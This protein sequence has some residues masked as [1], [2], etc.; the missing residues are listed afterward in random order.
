MADLFEYMKWRGDLSFKE[1]R[2]NEIDGMILSRAAYIPYALYLDN[3]QTDVRKVSDI[4]ELLLTTENYKDKVLWKE[5][6]DLTLWLKNSA[7]YSGLQLMYFEEL[8]D[9][10]TQTQFSAVTFK[11]EEGTYYV[12]FK[13]TDSSLVGWKEDFNMSFMNPVPSQLMAVEYLDEVAG[14]TEGDLILMG[15]SKG[16]NLA[17]YASAF[18]KEEIKDRIKT[19]YNYDGPGFHDAVLDT[20]EYTKGCSKVKTFVP[21]SSLIGLMMGHEEEHTIVKSRQITGIMQHD[22]YSW[23]VGVTKF[24]YLDTMTDSSKVLDR[25]LKNWVKG[26]SPEQRED[27]IDTLYGVLS[28]TNAETFEE[29]MKNWF[30]NAGIIVKSIFSMDDEAKKTVNE[31]TSAFIK[32][33]R[34]GIDQTFRKKKE[35]KAKVEAEKKVKARAIRAMKQQ[36]AKQHRIAVRKKK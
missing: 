29:L 35:E 31:G 6:A 9:K 8:I 22:V 33:L 28:K 20:D 11:D 1:N 15:H 34:E 30:E 24:V 2:F 17:V 21:Q 25:T 36:K 13:G 26:L 32:S 27:F 12:V 4:M 10:E 23:E 14:K 7:R 18:C 3:P 16:G 5:D 19:I